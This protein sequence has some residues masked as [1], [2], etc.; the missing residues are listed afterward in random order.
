MAYP[1]IFF[2]RRLIFVWSVIY[3][4]DFLW[5][6]LAIQTMTSVFIVQYLLW[7]WPLE[8]AF[9]VKMEVMNECTIVLMSYG[10]MCFTDFVPEPETRSL[11]GFYYIGIT[12]ANVLVHLIF[13]ALATC[14][15][16]KNYCK[17]KC[18]CCRR[19]RPQ[20]VKGPINTTPEV[21]E[22]Q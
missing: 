22:P 12:L 9:A 20:A 11:I 21:N 15:S 18:S 4:Q 13:L 6:Q 2:A 17:K 14:I 10:Q 5:A 7:F 3:L 16:L 8:S 1:V 19:K